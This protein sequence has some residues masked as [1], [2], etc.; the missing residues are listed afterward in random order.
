MKRLK[1]LTWLSILSVSTLFVSCKD[2]L[3]IDSYFDDEFKI[4][5]I[6]TQT[7]YVEAYMWG[8]A[9]MFTDEGQIFSTGSQDALETAG[10]R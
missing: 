3:N 4:D 1:L 7:R 9:T 2:F 5:S 6:F 8:A 10:Y